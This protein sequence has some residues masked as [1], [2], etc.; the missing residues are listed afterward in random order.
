MR[1]DEL[2]LDY[3]FIYFEATPPEI[4]CLVLGSG[5]NLLITN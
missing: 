4:Y 2:Y 3:D 1:I 5:G